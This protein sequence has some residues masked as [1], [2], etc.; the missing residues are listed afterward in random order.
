M[1]AEGLRE[2]A[3]LC[4]N[5]GVKITLEIH[6]NTIHD[7]AISTL[8]LLNMIDSPFGANYEKSLQALGSHG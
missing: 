6:M 7:S 2:I 4:E 3:K 5:E 1:A 8:K